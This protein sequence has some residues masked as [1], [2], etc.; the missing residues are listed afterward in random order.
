[1]AEIFLQR[2]LV[3]LLAEH[4]L[5]VTDLNDTER[6]DGGECVA[7]AA[8]Q[9]VGALPLH[10]ISRSGP[11]GS[12]RWRENTPGSSSGPFARSPPPRDPQ[13]RS[14]RH[15]RADCHPE[16]R[17]GQH[18]STRAVQTAAEEYYPRLRST[19][20]PASDCVVGLRSLTVCVPAGSRVEYSN[21]GAAPLGL[22]AT[23][24]LKKPTK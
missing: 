16:G 8:V 17:I 6:R 11:R 9:L 22:M 23:T 14:R 15:G 24:V 10:P 5:D 18:P 7:L 21:L 4:L 1:M 12:S 3:S 19:D 2:T 13:S 20:K